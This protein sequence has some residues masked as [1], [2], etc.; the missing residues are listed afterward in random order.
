MAEAQQRVFD[1]ATNGD[2][3]PVDESVHHIQVC[4]DEMTPGQW[5]YAEAK[6]AE[7]MVAIGH[8][9]NKSAHLRDTPRRYTQMLRELFHDESWTL[10]TFEQ[11]EYELGGR[12][13]PGIVVVR[14]IPL[15][16]MCAHHFAPF[17]GICHVA[18]IPHKQLVGLSKFAR[19][20]QSFSKGPNVQ[21]EI[22]MNIADFFVENIAPV[23]ISVYIKA[24]HTCMTHRG[25]KAH[26][27]DTVTHAV[28]GVFFDDD[29]ARAEVL[30]LITASN[31]N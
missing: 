24:T 17:E 4:P 15:R 2:E 13:D 30:R 25:V 6:F 3:P 1:W 27:S 31:G 12:G 7:F 23:G 28:R 11:P 21:E 9:P 22:G 16:S 29:A 10:T 8:S 26:G 5:K 14:N 18:Y 19:A 20:V